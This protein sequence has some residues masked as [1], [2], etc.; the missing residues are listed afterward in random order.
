M[1]YVN[2]FRT[3]LPLYYVEFAIFVVVF[4]HIDIQ[5]V[6]ILL[7][8]LDRDE[9]SRFFRQLLHSH[10]SLPLFLFLLQIIYH[11]ELFSFR[12]INLVDSIRQRCVRPPVSEI[13][14]SV[15]LINGLE[16]IGAR[17]NLQMVDVDVLV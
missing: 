13:L 6:Y 15:N 8:L 2:F 11:F 12:V 5:V 7:L 16:E 3:F 10:L 17:L 9:D 4:L 14:Q 1:I